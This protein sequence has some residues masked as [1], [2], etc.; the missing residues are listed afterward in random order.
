[1]ELEERISEVNRILKENYHKGITTGCVFL[2]FDGVINVFCDYG[3]ERWKKANEQDPDE[4]DFC[5]RDIVRIL[6][7]FCLEENMEIV[8]S[9]SW[10]FS[11]LDY[12]VQYL[13][14]YGLDERI[15][16]AG[17]TQIDWYMT[18]EEEIM[19]Y[20]QE[21]PVYAKIIILDDMVMPHL[22]RYIVQTDP[23]LGFDEE[24][25]QEAKKLLNEQI[26]CWTKETFEV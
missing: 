4:Y 16:V 24:R 9:S 26:F 17:T 1:M 22:K 2:D 15:K 11:G 25:A 8:I 5:D 18:R 13:R 23:F 20:I 19:A 10:R 14:H 12:C 21:H 6:S 7:S 3:S